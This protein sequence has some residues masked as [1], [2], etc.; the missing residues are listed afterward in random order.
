MPFMLHVIKRLNHGRQSLGSDRG[1][2]LV[3]FAL[4][5]PLL[6][7]V[8]L[9][10]ADFGRALGY[11]DDMTHL[12]NAAARYAAVN[13]NPGT[14]PGLSGPGHLDAYIKSTAPTGLQPLITQVSFAF[15]PALLP[16]N[17]CTGN[18][19]KVTVRATYTWLHFLSARHAAPTLSSTMTSTSTM[20]LEQNYKNDGTDA[21]TATGAQGTC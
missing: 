13:N 4:V 1:Q 17:H 7:L 10:I 11:K 18:P 14:G 8:V 21:Y 5:L 19:V 15:D 9:G 6:L 16:A 20:R 12:A 3:E 2:A